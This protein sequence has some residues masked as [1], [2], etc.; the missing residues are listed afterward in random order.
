MKSQ[1]WKR[2][3]SFVCEEPFVVV[4]FVLA[5][6]A[7]LPGCQLFDPGGQGKKILGASD[8]WTQFGWNEEEGTVT[9]DSEGNQEA[10]VLFGVGDLHFDQSGRLD[11]ES[12]SL[13][14]IAMYT[15]TSSGIQGISEDAFGASNRQSDNI[16]RGLTAIVP[17]I[18][19]IQGTQQPADVPLDEQQGAFLASMD[20]MLQD[21]GRRLEALERLP[22]AP[23]GGNSSVPP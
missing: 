3:V 12:S 5:L 7:W 17:L 8:Q 10:A 16:I 4:M 15:P 1:S 19:M 13:Q 21:F 11:L 20:Q 14:R 23:P 18:S 22:V 9:Y 2:V 6:L